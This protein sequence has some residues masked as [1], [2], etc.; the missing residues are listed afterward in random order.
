[1]LTNKGQPDEEFVV[2]GSYQTVDEAKSIPGGYEWAIHGFT[3]RADKNGY[4]PKPFRLM[5]GI[6]GVADRVSEI[7]P[8]L[9]KTLIGG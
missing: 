3:Y 2:T 8:S 1:M 7:S 4:Q 6:L 5:K 9:V